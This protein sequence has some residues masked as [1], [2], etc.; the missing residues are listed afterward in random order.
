[1]IHAECETHAL[2]WSQAPMLWLSLCVVI[3]L[4]ILFSD[5]GYFFVVALGSAHSFISGFLGF[6]SSF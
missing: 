2:L 4:F 3:D 6:V 1:M 5:A